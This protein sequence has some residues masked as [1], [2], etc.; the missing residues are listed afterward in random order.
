MANFDHF[1]NSTRY[2]A[3]VTDTLNTAFNLY[4]NYDQAGTADPRGVRLAYALHSSASPMMPP[5][6]E[7]P[8]SMHSG[9]MAIRISFPMLLRRGTTSPSCELLL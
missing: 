9:H 5:G 8:H 6:G 2:Q 3:Q 7:Q 4:P 1:T